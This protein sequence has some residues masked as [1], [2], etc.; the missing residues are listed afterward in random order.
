MKSLK[1][2]V[3]AVKILSKSKIQEPFGRGV[4]YPQHAANALIAE[5]RFSA[6][7]EPIYTAAKLVQQVNTVLLQNLHA[8]LYPAATASAPIDATW[9]R[10][11]ELLD[12]RDET[13][14]DAD[15][16]AMLEAFLMLQ[17][18]P[19]LKGMTAR[20]LRA[21]WRSRHRID[22]AFRRG[23]GNRARFIAMF[24]EPRGLTHQLRRMNL[25]GIL[26]QYLPEFGAFVGLMQHDLFHVYTVDEHILRVMRNLRRFT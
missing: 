12:L 26:G 11:D 24:R 1:R 9:S 7:D 14:F 13:L 19:E 22:A 15:P 5:E 20:T 10:V 3:Y 6:W 25:Y 18:H 8:S 4:A 2:I 21:L 23:A 17:R 16:S